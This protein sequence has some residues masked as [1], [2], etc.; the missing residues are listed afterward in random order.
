[1]YLNIY[2]PDQT[3][4]RFTIKDPPAIPRVGESMI[5]DNVDGDWT[6]STRLEVKA[7]AW[8]VESP[9]GL[10]SVSVFLGP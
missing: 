5:F 9:T 4:P 1:M 3:A 7:V 6:N 10:K 8:H 2:I